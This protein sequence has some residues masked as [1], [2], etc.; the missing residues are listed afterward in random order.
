MAGLLKIRGSEI[1]QRYTELM[2]L[3]RRP[4]SV[5]F[6][7]GDGAGWQGDT[8]ARRTARRWPPP[9]STTAKTTIYGGSNEVQRNIVS[10][11][12]SW[13]LTMDFFDFTDD[14]NRCATRCGAGS[15]RASAFER[16]HAIA[17]AGGATRRS[18]ASSPTWASPAWA[19]PEAQGRHGLRRR[20][21]RWWSTRN[22]AAAWSM[23]LM[24]RVRSSRRRCCRRASADLQ[25]QWLP[26]IADGLGAG[27]AGA[28]GT[29][30]ALPAEPRHD[31]A[32]R[33]PPAAG[34][35]LRAPRGVVPAGDEAD[36]FI[37][38]AQRMPTPMPR[39]SPCSSSPR[40]RSRPPCAATRRR[41]RARAPRSR[42][43]ARRPR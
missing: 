13:E 4:V 21:R 17:K 33:R 39:A 28:S 40:R 12:R 34:W 10:A 23:R 26:K 25:A 5:P 9:I 11:N 32:N 29:R 3:G 27:G 16:R 36:A 20:S 19:I 42:S 30:G 24:R 31:R 43:P 7:K 1:Q 22:W 35:T 2:M 8:S 41:T 14:P 18:T 6:V 38:P 37:V 15:R